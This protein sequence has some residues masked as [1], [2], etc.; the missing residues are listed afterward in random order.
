MDN[1]KNEERLGRAV[2]GIA[3]FFFAFKFIAVVSLIA[4]AVC[5]IAGKPLWIAPIAAVVLF[6]LYRAV[7]RLFFRFIRW[8]TKD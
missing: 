2:F 3:W 4:L 7:W 1:S 8:S 6:I 5:W